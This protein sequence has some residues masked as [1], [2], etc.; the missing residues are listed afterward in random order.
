MV[1]LNLEALVTDGALRAAATKA[2]TQEEVVA[3]RG[4]RQRELAAV[5][6]NACREGMQRWCWL[7]RMRQDRRQSL[8]RLRQ[9]SGQP[10]RSAKRPTAVAGEPPTTQ[11]GKPK[12]A[13]GAKSA[14]HA[15]VGLA[16]VGCD[17]SRSVAAVI[18][19]QF[20]DPAPNAPR[21]RG[22]GPCL[23][24]RAAQPRGWASAL[25]RARGPQ[26]GA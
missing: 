18:R 6:H 22:M 2:A 24:N 15:Q 14:G 12:G 16:Q 5:W 3:H 8:R 21:R 26:A 1:L 9:G 13:A 10:Q 7:R 19:T 11:L 23:T 25:G 4:L 20:S 17:R